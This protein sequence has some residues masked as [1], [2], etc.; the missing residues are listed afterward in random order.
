MAEIV[1][2]T[3]DAYV[4]RISLVRV[5]SGTL[6]PDQTVH[7]SG[8]F[9]ADRGHEDHDEDERIGALSSPLGKPCAR[10]RTATPATSVWL[11]RLTKAETGD[12]LSG[13]DKP[14]L[15]EAWEM[16]EP[17]F[18]VAIDAHGKADEDKLSHGLAACGRGSDDATRAEP[19]DPPVGSLDDG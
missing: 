2:T 12:T 4:G 16:P 7:V 6:R 19:R 18:P 1:K 15:M 5:F 10:S 11:A 3:T 9:L 14:L 17:L 13:K 8:H